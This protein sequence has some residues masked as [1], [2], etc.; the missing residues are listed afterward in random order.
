MPHEPDVA[1]REREQPAEAEVVDYTKGGHPSPLERMTLPRDEQGIAP[2]IRRDRVRLDREIAAR[3][4]AAES[5]GTLTNWADLEAA[6]T[7]VSHDRLVD[8]GRRPHVET[9]RYDELGRPAARYRG[10]R[11]RNGLWR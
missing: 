7:S 6:A 4:I 9:P 5:E 2:D 10:N 11:E 3:R 8:F 1:P